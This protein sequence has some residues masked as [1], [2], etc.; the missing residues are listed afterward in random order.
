MNVK[1]GYGR[2]STKK[3]KLAAQRSMLKQD[4][5]ALIFLETRSGASRNCPELMRALKALR[6]G[7]T[8]VVYKL[9]RLTRNLGHLIEIIAELRQRGIHLRSLSE[10][11]DIYTPMGKFTAY[12][13]GA[14]AELEFDNI[15]ERT[16]GGMRFAK[17]CGRPL[18]RRSKM[19]E[20]QLARARRLADDKV[21]PAAIAAMMHVGRTTVYRALESDY[22]PRRALKAKRAHV[23]R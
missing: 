11:V 8:L 10:S 21:S 6:P 18:G 5:C 2:V 3:Q 13:I 15:A 22:T 23:G 20:R 16:E 14:I 4:G 12:L 9:D 7:D 19:T 1:V 17:Q